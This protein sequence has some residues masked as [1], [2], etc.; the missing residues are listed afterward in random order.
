MKK[1]YIKPEVVFESFSLSHNI[2]AGCEII[3]GTPSEGSCDYE[4]EG[5]GGQSIFVTT[6]IC[7]IPVNDDVSNGFCYH[8]PVEGNNLF[9][10]L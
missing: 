10:S 9:N 8:V 7:D 5:G 1:T 4:Y 3:V 2:A 6:G